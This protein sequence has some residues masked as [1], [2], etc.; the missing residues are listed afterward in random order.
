MK[1]KRV[2]IC[3]TLPVNMAVK[4]DGYAEDM[5][6]DRSHFLQW[7]LK[8]ALPA[9]PEVISKAKESFKKSGKEFYEWL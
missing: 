5:T 3:F 6:L 9:I 2:T 8:F 1:E 4:L 7:L